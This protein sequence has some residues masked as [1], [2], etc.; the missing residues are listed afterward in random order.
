M[1]AEPG[2]SGKPV[3]SAVLAFGWGLVR[4]IWA[5]RILRTHPPGVAGPSEQRHPSQLS[6]IA[7]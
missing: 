2:R 4:V 7:G 3:A 1:L 5:I 6:P